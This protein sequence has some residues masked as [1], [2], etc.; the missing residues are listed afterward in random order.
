MAASQSVA[1]TTG[2]GINT[3]VKFVGGAIAFAAT[4]IGAN[5]RDFAVGVAKGD[6]PAVVDSKTIATK[7]VRKAN[8]TRTRKSR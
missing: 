4:K 1:R 7:Q 5:L 2:A 3:G 6:D 8:K